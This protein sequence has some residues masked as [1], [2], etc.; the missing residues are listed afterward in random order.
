MLRLWA[1]HALHIGGG[2]SGY[3]THRNHGP[4]LSHGIDD[5]LHQQLHLGGLGEGCV[6]RTMWYLSSL[7]WSLMFTVSCQERIWHAW[8]GT[9]KYCAI[10]LLFMTGRLVDLAWAKQHQKLLTVHMYTR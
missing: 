5:D 7:E 10:R 9:I 2:D 3:Q 1:L 4:C 6:D 8:F